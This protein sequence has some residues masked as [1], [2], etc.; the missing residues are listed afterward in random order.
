[1]NKSIYNRF[2]R[3]N[4]NISRV[5]YEIGILDDFSVDEIVNSHDDFN[6]DLNQ[7]IKNEIGSSIKV[8]WLRHPYRDRW[9]ADPFILDVTADKIYLLVEEY[10]Y[11]SNK[12][13]IA[14]LEIDRETC[15]LLQ[16]EVVLELETHLSFPIIRRIGEDVFIYPENSQAGKLVI[17]RLSKDFSYCNE[18][19]V[20][21]DEPL[22]D[23]VIFQDL[24]FST[25]QPTPNGCYLSIYKYNKELGQYQ[26]SQ[27]IEFGEKI[28][29]NAGGYFIYEGRMFR[30]AQECNNSYGHCV[31][32]QELIHSENLW[33]MNE[34]CRLYSP[35]PL[36]KDGMHTFNTY[37]DVGVIDVNGPRH[38][39]MKRLVD[40]MYRFYSHIQHKS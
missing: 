22:T 17:Y 9:F 21:I 8:K 36:M 2:I 6:S 30:P 18:S 23:A 7:S 31:V 13:R 38:P 20:L 27:K 11:Q 14:K 19:K 26:I 25:V 12:G 15:K 3:F 10:F 33:G 4:E 39:V 34:V 37:K 29:R 35:H 16:I 1:M 40:M 24:I 5:R 32:I 28:A